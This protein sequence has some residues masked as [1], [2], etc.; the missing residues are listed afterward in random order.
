MKHEITI[1]TGESTFQ[2]KINFI[3]SNINSTH[4]LCQLSSGNHTFCFIPF[5]KKQQQQNS[6][7]TDT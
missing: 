6:F 5:F 1:T 7:T 3:G 2:F 4:V